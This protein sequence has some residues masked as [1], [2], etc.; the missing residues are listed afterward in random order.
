MKKGW[1]SL[2]KT[3][4]SLKISYKILRHNIK[5][6]E[7][8]LKTSQKSVLVY[9]YSVYLIISRNNFIR[10][11]FLDG[12]VGRTSQRLRNRTQQNVPKAI[13]NTTV[14]ERKQPERQGKSVNSIPHCDSAIGNHLLDNQKCASNYKDNQFFILSEARYN[15]HSSVFVNLIFV[16]RKSLFTNI[17]Y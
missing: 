1:T 10:K 16:D 12:Y 13:R 14:Q 2:D 5:L 3:I 4:F 11:T 7:F 6:I 17:N 9:A 15:F 8:K